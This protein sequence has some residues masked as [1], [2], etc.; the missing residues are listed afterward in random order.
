MIMPNISGEVIGCV[1]CAYLPFYF[2]STRPQ[3]CWYGISLPHFQDFWRVALPPNLWRNNQNVVFRLLTLR[4]KQISIA[5]AVA[6]TSVVPS[7]KRGKLS[8]LYN[9]AESLGRFTSATGFAVLFAWSISPASFGWIDHHFVFYASALAMGGVT[10]LAWCTL[11]QDIFHEQPG[12]TPGT[13]AG[14][15][16]ADGG[17]VEVDCIGAHV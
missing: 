6:S 16:V 5:L 10:V 13:N 7:S 1:G 14:A 12:I 17:Y 11:S 15:A 8:G 3:R 2:A 9:T 4:R